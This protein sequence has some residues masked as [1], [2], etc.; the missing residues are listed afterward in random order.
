MVASAP[1]NS[2]AENQ[3]SAP[4]L[5]EVLQTPSAETEELDHVQDQTETATAK[6]KSPIKL[7]PDDQYDRGTPRSSVAG[8]I[9]A[10]KNNDFERAAEYLDLRN[11]PQGYNKQDGPELARQLKIVLDRSLWIDMDLL[12]TDP[13]GHT[14]DGLPSYRDLLGQIQSAG[15]KTD[16][17]LQRVPRGDGVTIW[18]FSSKLV[19]NIPSLY[20]KHGYGPIGERLSKAFPSDRFLGFELWQW[21]FLLLLYISCAII[22]LPFVRLISWWIRRKQYDLSPLISRFINGPI[23][24]VTVIFIVRH[25]FDVIHP[26]LEAKAIFQ[27]ATVTILVVTWALLRLTDLFRDFWINRLKQNGK[28]HSVVLIKPAMTGLNVLIVVL[29][30]LVWL[31]NIGFSVTTVIAGLGIGGIAIALATQKSIEHFIGAITIYL[32]APVRVGDFCRF[33]DTFGVVE[34]IG[35]RSTTLRTLDRTAVIIPNA[36]F[37]GMPIENYARRDNIRFNPKISLRNDTS[38]DQIRFILIELQ[39]LLHAHPK[40]VDSAPRARFTGFGNHSLDIDIHCY[41]TTVDFAEYLSIAEDLNLRIMDIIHHA[42]TQIAIPAR[43]EFQDKA[44][45]PNPDDKEK[46]E[47]QVAKWRGQDQMLNELTQ[48]QIDE[49]KNTIAY[50][51][52]DNQ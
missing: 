49:I 16:V 40:V 36:D 23:H 25:F 15:K 47:A 44:R 5:K 33:G 50:P 34:E 11:L 6:K 31:D 9:L 12:S 21:F 48:E 19:G 38:A 39:K 27:A 52:K 22:V 20:E 7:G 14:E 32:A 37:A 17:L 26:S 4:T 43:I 10:V 35:L 42:G 1:L 3:L 29:A 46:A 8:Y 2:Y 30:F 24:V 41:I 45:Q 13:K 28:E 51:S 18:K